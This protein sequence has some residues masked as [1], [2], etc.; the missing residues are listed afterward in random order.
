MLRR[1]RRWYLSQFRV[2]WNYIYILNE[3]TVWTAGTIENIKQISRK[4]N[5]YGG[6][7]MPYQLD[8]FA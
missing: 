6:Y 4:K 7:G 5:T 2:N 3:S 8:Y 1:I